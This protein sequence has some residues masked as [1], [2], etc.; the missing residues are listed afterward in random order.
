[1]HEAQ[2]HKDNCFLTLTYRDDQLSY[3]NTQATL[4]KPDLQRFW[5]RL[6]KELGKREIRY[7]ACGEYGEQYSRPHYHSCLFGFD[8]PDKTLLRSEGDN[9]LYSSHMLDRIWSHGHCSIG[10][11]TAHSAAYVAR[12]ILD[13]KLGEKNFYEEKGIEPEFILMSRGSNKRGTGG[14][15]YGWFKNYAGDIYPQDKCIGQDGKTASR[16]PRYYDIL[17]ERTNPEEIRKIKLLRMEAQDMREY[18]EK[19]AV[20]MLGKIKYHESR[21]KNSQRRMHK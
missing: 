7:F 11:L 15:G 21:I 2:M 20:R 12:Y 1:M 4:F 3:G 10:A 19:S 16:P 18:S 13:K 14:I 5:K 17:R 6:R 9:N 8:F